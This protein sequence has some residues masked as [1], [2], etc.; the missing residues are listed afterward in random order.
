MIAWGGRSSR[1]WFYDLSAGPES[2]TNNWIVDDDQ[3]EY[4][5]PPVWEYRAG[6][7]RAPS[8]LTDLARVARMG[9]F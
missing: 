4:H 2:S 1:I 9:H 5:M 3:T 8:V 7:Y 6:G